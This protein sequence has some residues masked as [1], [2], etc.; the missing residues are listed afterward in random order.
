M[1]ES[2]PSR[3]RGLGHKV[4]KCPTGPDCD[5]EVAATLLWQVAQEQRGKTKYEQEKEEW[6]DIMLPC[7]LGTSLE[8]KLFAHT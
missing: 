7:E 1:P 8:D 3:S 2:Q 5:V 4:R 6:F